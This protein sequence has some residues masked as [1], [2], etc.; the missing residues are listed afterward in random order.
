[1]TSTNF[2]WGIIGFIITIVSALGAIVG[3]AVYG[4]ADPVTI[5]ALSLLASNSLVALSAIMNPNRK[6]QDEVGEMQSAKRELEHQAIETQKAVS[7][8]KRILK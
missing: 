1:M 5:G 4:Y 3:L 2:S 7:E 6:L 8:I